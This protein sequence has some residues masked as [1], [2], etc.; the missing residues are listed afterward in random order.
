MS[1]APVSEP[2][3]ESRELRRVLDEELHRLPEKYRAP[4]ILC[5]LEGK[6]NEEAARLLGWPSGSMSHRLARGRELLRHRLQNQTGRDNYLF[7]EY[8]SGR[9]LPA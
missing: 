1:S 7:A 4:L 8:F 3:A 5:Y 6:T 9:I 2:E